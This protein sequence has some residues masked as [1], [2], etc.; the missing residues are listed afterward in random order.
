MVLHALIDPR[1]LGRLADFYPD[2]VTIQANS[3]T[4]DA[5]GQPIPS[6]SAVAGLADLPCAVG[7]VVET[8]I[9]RAESRRPAFT[10]STRNRRISIAGAYPTIT[11]AHRALVNGSDAYTIVGAEVDSHGMTTRLLCE[12]VST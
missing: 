4:R 11:T 7:P 5:D 2:A 8:S 9:D 1:M 10:V 6:W 12:I 3:P